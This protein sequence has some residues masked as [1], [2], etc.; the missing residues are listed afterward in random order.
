MISNGTKGMKTCV[1]IV[2]YVVLLGVP[3]SI[4]NEN[5]Q[6]VKKMIKFN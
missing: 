1:K 6:D 5:S 2:E 4:K 3:I